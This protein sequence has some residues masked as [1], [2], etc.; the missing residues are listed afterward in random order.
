ME[1]GRGESVPLHNKELGFNRRFATPS[2][3][4]LLSLE[5]VKPKRCVLVYVDQN[6]LRRCAKEGCTGAR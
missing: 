1:G 6:L 4:C 2:A 5:G 3:Q